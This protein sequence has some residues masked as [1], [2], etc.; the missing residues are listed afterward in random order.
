M[1]ISAAL[2][3]FVAS[4]IIR[5]NYPPEREY[6]YSTL[7]TEVVPLQTSESVPADLRPQTPYIVV[8]ASLIRAG[9][10]NSVGVADKINTVEWEAI[11]YSATDDPVKTELDS[12]RLI[13]NLSNKW[14]NSH[15]LSLIHI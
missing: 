8:W 12:Q 10:V 11:F 7:Y 2:A 4:E 3:D 13:I 15:G 9:Q 14:Y 1:S 6:E 5:A